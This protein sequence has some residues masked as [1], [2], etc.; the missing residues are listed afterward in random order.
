MRKKSL[1]NNKYLLIALFVLLIGGVS[2]G[3]ALISSYVQIN[4][5]AKIGEVNWDVRFTNVDT[6]KPGNVTLVTTDCGGAG[7]P[8]CDIAPRIKTGTNDTQAEWSVTL[9]QPGDQYSFSID[10]WNKGTLDALLTNVSAPTGTNLDLTT[11]EEVYLNYTITST[12]IDN[13]VGPLPAES[14]T[15]GA[16]ET[17]VLKAGK[18]YRLTFTIVYDSTIQ[19]SQIPDGAQTVNLGY[20]LD[21][22]QNS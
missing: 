4:G 20:K 1:F 10:V 13:D 6:A 16:G 3:F 14:A 15:A 11:A 7:Q 22:Q 5:K 9:N 21:F 8:E 18:K 12:N 2:V 17:L 19:A